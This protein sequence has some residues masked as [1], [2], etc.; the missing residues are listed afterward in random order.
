MLPFVSEVEEPF[1][2]IHRSSERTFHV[3]EERGLQEIRRKVARVHRDKCAILPL[4]VRMDGPGDKL[5]A[6]PAFALDQ[7]GRAARR[8]LDDEVEDAPHRRSAADDVIEVAVLFLDVLP[9]RA[10]LVDQ[11]PALQ[12]VL[13][14]HEHFVVLEGLRNV[15]ERPALH[16][17]DGVLHRRVRRH[18]D[19]RQLVIQ[20]LERFERGHAVDAGHHHVDDGGVERDVSGQ[21]DAFLAAGGEP[22]GIPLA[23]QQ[24]FEDLA[25]DFFVVYNE[26]RTILL[27]MLTF[28]SWP[29]PVARPR[30]TPVTKR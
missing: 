13:D 9:E 23:L 8:C 3:A 6:R 4:R 7:N 1:L 30:P 18:H 26:N 22:H 25:H 19:D 15:V 17:R 14:H 29:H 2:G 27:H 21:L 12:R 11:A 20:L 28:N 16:R 10:I 24:G 5:F